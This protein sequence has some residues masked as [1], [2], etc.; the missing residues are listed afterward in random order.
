M[1]KKK[2]EPRDIA[3][4]RFEMISPLLDPDLDFAEKAIRRE[5]ILA[6][7]E[8]KGKPISAR[9]L[10][11]YLQNY[12]EQGFDGLHPRVRSDQGR[13]RVLR[14]E[15]LEAAV[16]LK[17]ELPRR[18]VRQIIEI[19][20][21][22][23]KV[24]A[25]ILRPSTLSRHFKQ[26]GLM[27]LEKH[28]QVKGGYRRFQKERPNQMWQ[29]DLK[30]GVY[31]PDPENP[32][33]FRKT[34]LLALIDDHSRLVTHAEFYF[35]QD[36]PIL[37]DCFRKAVLKRGLP[38]KVYVDHGK[39][40]VSRWFRLAC[41]RLNVKHRTTNTYSPYEKGKIERFMRTVEQFLDEAR[42]IRFPTLKELNTAFIIWLEE[43]YNHH[44]HSALT[45]KDGTLR[46]PAEVFKANAVKL[47]FVSI[48]ELRDAFM[49]ED[50]RVVRKDGC[51]S[52]H[53][54]EFDAGPEYVGKKV[55]IRYDRVKPDFVE[56]WENGIK[57]KTVY[58]K[59]ARLQIMDSPPSPGT[60]VVETD[61]SRLLDL[62]EKQ[63][64]KRRKQEL[65][66][67]SYRK[68]GGDSDV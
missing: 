38:E 40:F 56:I 23:G 11:R 47:R 59:G 17:K 58:P 16:I 49:W 8:A 68:L 50:D 66:A 24:N 22:E 52:L 39:I 37:E 65:G 2:F 53:K 62:L 13:P 14:Q 21:G 1:E 12:R 3:L 63:G 15:L 60:G 10:R 41:A 20:E 35:K 61:N 30:D 34:Y 31:L 32:K 29:M 51:L 9:T 48:E 44:S 19:L 33:K 42:L 5:A 25:G 6:A 7:Q 67:I 64:K 43:G 45:A 28:V 27:E 36:Y 26:L 18:S 55:E 57:K 4:Q 46:T 54:I